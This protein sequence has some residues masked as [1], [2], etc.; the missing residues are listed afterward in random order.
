MS[1]PSR[2]KR[3]FQFSLRAFLICV[4]VFAAGLAFHTRRVKQANSRERAVESLRM[5]GAT[6][7]Y[8]HE[9]KGRREP[10]TGWL[11]RLFGPEY[12]RKVHS[13]HFGHETRDGLMSVFD[14]DLELLGDLPNTRELSLIT[15]NVT[16]DGL[17]SLRHLKKLES[18]RFGVSGGWTIEGDGRGLAY[19]GT[20]PRLRRLVLHNVPPAK[21]GL[22]F[23]YALPELE[24]LGLVDMNVSDHL[25]VLR[26]LSGLKT[27]NMSGSDV[28]DDALSPVVEVT[29]LKHLDLSG[30]KVTDRGLATLAKLKHLTTLNV[31][32]TAVTHVG[33]TA[34]KQALPSCDVRWQP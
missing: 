26:K 24:E 18:F 9:A 16:T 2:Q 32:L 1:E 3:L 19:I 11:V 4:A 7:R 17:V 22:S 15:S 31:R 14:D 25:E 8:Q 20:C 23:L 28:T 30:T 5:C 34:I 33:V 10:T 29:S 6:V 27:L 13:L 12:F 21:N